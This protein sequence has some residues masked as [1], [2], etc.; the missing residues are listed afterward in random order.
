MKT[1]KLATIFFVVLG[2]TSCSNEEETFVIQNEAA[3]SLLNSYEIQRNADGSYFVDYKTKGATSDNVRDEK[4]NE[5]TINLYPDNT[6]TSRNQSEDLGFITD[7]DELKIKFNDIQ[8]SKVTSI[9]VKD[10]K[11]SLARSNNAL[12]RDFNF[13]AQED[14]TYDLS[15]EVKNKVDVDFV[16]NDDYQS[17]DIILTKGKG[18]ESNFLRTFTPDD[19]GYLRIT[20]VTP[21]QSNRG[22]TQRKP[23][24][25]VGG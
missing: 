21:N 3:E 12:L 18:A 23:D 11:I 2:L 25:V 24:I 8:A 9:S 22:V 7:G 14:G 6:Q 16:Y 20:F 5:N 19:N 1:L 4:R 13:K 15:F 17:Y 10:D